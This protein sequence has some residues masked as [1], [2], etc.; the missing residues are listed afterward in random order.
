M[1][2]AHEGSRDLQPRLPLVAAAVAVHVR[3][4]EGLLLLL[5]LIRRGVW[6]WRLV[7]PALLAF[8][9]FLGDLY[10]PRERATGVGRE[11]SGIISNIYGDRIGGQDFSW[12]PLTATASRFG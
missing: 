2:G 7:L 5:L 9:A 11:G 6:L 8:L 1:P 3:F 4:G 12:L 10:W